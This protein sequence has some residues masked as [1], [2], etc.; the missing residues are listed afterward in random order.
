[1]MNTFSFENKRVLITGGFGFIGSHLIRRLLQE[2][3]QV[4]VLVRE[5]S[6]PWRILDVLKNVTV[7]HADIQ[8]RAEVLQATVPF[9]PHYIFHLAAYGVNTKQKSDIDALQINVLGTMNIVHAAHVV[10]CDKLINL[11]SSSEYG[12]KSMAIHEEMLLSPVDIYGSTKAAATILSHQMALEIKLPI[13][14]LRPFGIFGEGED[15]D[16][17]FSYIIKSLLRNQE[18]GLTSCE[19]FRD[20]CYVGNIIDGMVMVALDPSI[21]N[22]IFNIGSGEVYPLKHFVSLIF[23]HMETKQEPVYGAIPDRINERHCPLPDISKIKT[24]LHWKPTETLE[25]GLIRTINWYKQNSN[26]FI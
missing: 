19:Q 12:D 18:V 14:T 23:Y 16:K 21:Q 10:G 17:L 6:N 20:Y 4:A 9:A 5:T 22:D 15:P 26:L 3:A 13:V 24:T 1:M 8:N 7:F 11:G 2:K 25:E